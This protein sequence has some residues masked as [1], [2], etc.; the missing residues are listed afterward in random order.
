MKISTIGK[1]SVMVFPETPED[2]GIMQWLAKRFE[3]T[4]VTLTFDTTQYKEHHYYPTLWV[5]PK[6]WLK[7]E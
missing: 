1:G 5:T 4:E 3:G 2:A 6:K 7:S